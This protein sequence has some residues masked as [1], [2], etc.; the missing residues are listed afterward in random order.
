MPRPC[1][2]ES[3]FEISTAN[4]LTTLLSFDV[5]NGNAPS[6]TLLQATN[7]TLYGTTKLGGTPGDGT[8]YSLG[9]GL[10]AVRGSVAHLRC[11][12]SRRHYIGKQLTGTTSVTFNG[13]SAT[14]K[15]VSSTEITT[16]V[17]S[18]VTTARLR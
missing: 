1:A 17:P 15:V 2:L 5:T 14:F 16:T 8:I 18:G 12:G 13:T 3:L 11:G 9:E 6:G 10:W 7:G 4:K